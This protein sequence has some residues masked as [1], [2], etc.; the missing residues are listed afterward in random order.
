VGIEP[1]IEL[2]QKYT[3]NFKSLIH[4]LK[5]VWLKVLKR[6]FQLLYK[7]YLIAILVLSLPPDVP[8]RIS[9][10]LD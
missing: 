1:A 3:K 7:K 6:R 2:V 5:K 4:I 10:T 9:Q 8:S